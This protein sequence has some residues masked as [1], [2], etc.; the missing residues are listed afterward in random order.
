MKSRVLALLLPV[1]GFSQPEGDDDLFYFNDKNEDALL[2]IGHDSGFQPPLSE[3]KGG[4]DDFD[5][6][7]LSLLEQDLSHKDDLPWDEE[8]TGPE[9]TAYIKDKAQKMTPD[10]DDVFV[11]D[12]PIGGEEM[13]YAPSKENIAGTSRHFF[14]RPRVV[15]SKPKSS[16]KKATTVKRGAKRG[17]IITNRGAGES[18]AEE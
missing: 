10:Y 15:E 17:V 1:M 6:E 11:Y 18:E 4:S 13:G 3:S 2:H 5:Q 14:G 8:I 7:M 9:I 16:S 12:V